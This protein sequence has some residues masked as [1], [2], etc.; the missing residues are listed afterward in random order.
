MNTENTQAKR[1]P[2]EIFEKQDKMVK[3]L[4]A[5][6]GTSGDNTWMPTRFL[7]KRLEAAGLV[8]FT[9]EQSGGRGRPRNVPQLADAGVVYLA[10]ARR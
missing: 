4:R 1:G 6:R 3:A 9:Q 7:L 2:K 8:E 10:N 5:V